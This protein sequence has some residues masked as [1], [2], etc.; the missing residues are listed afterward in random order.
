MFLLLVKR[1]LLT[2]NSFRLLDAVDFPCTGSSLEVFQLLELNCDTLLGDR[3][4]KS[5]IMSD[6]DQCTL[7]GTEKALQPKS[8]FKVLHQ[9][10]RIGAKLRNNTSLTKKFV[11]SSS[12]RTSLYIRR[13]EASAHRIRHPPDSAENGP[14]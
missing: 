11:G 4:K 9:D 5:D 8:R 14:A 10:V 3:V 1:L 2:L 6:D 7:S 13:A 12:M